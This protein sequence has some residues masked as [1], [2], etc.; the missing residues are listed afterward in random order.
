MLV[1]NAGSSAECRLQH[2]GLDER[3]SCMPTPLTPNAFPGQRLQQDDAD[4]AQQGQA[5]GQLL[6][7][8]KLLEAEGLG[9]LD[10]SS[11]AGRYPA[12]RHGE[13]RNPAGGAGAAA[14]RSGSGASQHG[15]SKPPGRRTSASLT[16]TPMRMHWQPDHAAAV[17]G[18]GHP[19]GVLVAIVLEARR[20]GGLDVSHLQRW[21]KE[22]VKD[23]CVRRGW[24]W[25]RQLNCAQ[26]PA[27]DGWCVAVRPPHL[28]RTAAMYLCGC[29]TAS[30]N[31]GPSA[32]RCL[33]YLTAA[34]LRPI[35]RL[36]LACI[37]C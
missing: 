31:D 18:C 20:V 27:S 25:R 22:C 12:A 37:G 8:H 33:L 15:R 26:R 35:D 11:E 16:S 36:T 21:I 6:L 7:Q 4:D 2:M 1:P 5:D 14:L 32:P 17:S 3:G 19:L 34:A 23:T 9:A 28:L 30:R 29:D 24:E 10:V 13:A